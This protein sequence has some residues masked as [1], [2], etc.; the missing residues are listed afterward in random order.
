MP[1]IMRLPIE[2]A[3]VTARI[4]RLQQV[5]AGLGVLASA[6]EM[7]LRRQNLSR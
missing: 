5:S 7:L 2:A 1:L 4:E 3:Q 6:A